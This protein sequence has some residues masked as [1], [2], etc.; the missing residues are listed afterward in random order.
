MNKT[1]T[2]ILKILEKNKG[3]AVSGEQ[4]AKE[5]NLTRSAVWKNINHLKKE[6]YQILSTN[7]KG[8]ELSVENDIFN[9][10]SIYEA[11]RNDENFEIATEFNIAVMDEVGSTN[12]L[13]KE[14]AR[15][16]AKEGRVLVAKK[17][18]EGRGRLGRSFFSPKKGLYLSF[19][20]RP[21]ISFRESLLLTTIAA[22]S[23]MEAIKEVTGKSAGIKWVNDVYLD[24]KKIC[25]ILTEA[26]ADVENGSLA[27]A[28][29][30][31]GINIT[32]PDE[33]VPEELKDIAGFLYD[34]E[35]SPK[36]ILTKLTAAVIQR[37]FYYY[38]R[39]PE[40]YFIEEYKK[41][42]ILIGKE[43]YVISPEMKK[44]AM[45]LGV[46]D[47]ARLLVEY[48]DGNRDSLFTGEVSVREVDKKEKNSPIFQNL[49]KGSF[50]LVFFLLLPLFYGCSKREAKEVESHLE[51]SESI[52]RKGYTFHAF[53]EEFFIGED[54]HEKLKRL[55]EPNSTNEVP[56]CARLGEDVI[57]TYSGFSLTTSKKGEDSEVLYS[58]LL[59]DDSVMTD[60][61]LYIGD[62][63]DKV[64]KLYGN[65]VKKAGVYTY[66]KDEMKLNIVMK[67]D[68]VIS[69]E[70]SSI[71]N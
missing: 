35:G 32:E 37:Y 10:E 26:E 27:Y 6:G 54:I 38:E 14:E 40:H 8:Y 56:S 62:N 19:L 28:V 57:Y 65:N 20:L 55:S 1:A 25:G 18:T 24:G 17:Q 22:V 67:K 52:V 2:E 59:T 36:G 7:N 39:L 34:R 29:V 30:G 51:S 48:E 63:D 4:I 13:L 16:G 31:I 64:L 49:K 69:I 9:A 5:L 50:I 44:K 70:Y 12:S 47:E 71:D 41:N 61:G 43:I 58:I 11:L 21:N 53:D 46:D 15:T 33:G 23:V 45:V 66:E 3:R 42:Q 60:E 68:T